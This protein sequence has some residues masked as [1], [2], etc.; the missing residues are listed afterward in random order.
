MVMVHALIKMQAALRCMHG[1]TVITAVAVPLRTMM[2]TPTGCAV[3]EGIPLV[4]MSLG[5]EEPGVRDDSCR[6]TIA[7]DGVDSLMCITAGELLSHR[8]PVQEM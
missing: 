5:M 8:R 4:A 7:H 3:V 1:L 2:Q 6:A